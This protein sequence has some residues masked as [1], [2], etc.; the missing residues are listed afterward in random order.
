LTNKNIY[1]IITISETQKTHPVIQTVLAAPLNG[2]AFHHTQ[3]Q[4]QKGLGFER[5]ETLTCIIT[6]Y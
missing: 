5:A 1:S 6:H 2:Q 4:C 3:I